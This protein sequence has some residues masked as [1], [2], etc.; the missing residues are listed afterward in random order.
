MSEAFKI[1]SE[2]LDEAMVDAKEPK[3]ERQIVTKEISEPKREE[4][5]PQSKAG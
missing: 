1:L 5:S 3:L 2:A 4:D